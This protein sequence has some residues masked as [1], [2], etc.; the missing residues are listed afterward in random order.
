MG[1]TLARAA[2]PSDWDAAARLLAEHQQWVADALDLDLTAAQPEAGGE[3]T[4]PAS[5][6]RPPDGALV[7]VRSGQQP[8][9]IVGI[10][11]YA[12]TVGEL[13]RMYVQ[14]AA[15]GHGI[16]R[17]LVTAALAAAAELG[18]TELWLQT[19][20][21]TMAAAHRLYRD[22]GF[23][24]IPPY[25]DLGIAGVATLGLRLGSDNPVRSGSVRRRPLLPAV[26]R[27]PRVST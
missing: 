5:F 22:A 15:R 11:R 18:F 23:V 20:P 14:P 17:V 21:A 13:K 26:A 1:I 16:G 27:S 7:L 24:D 25:H 3:F 8:I 10:H 2:T 19:E 9:G 6:Y 12:G 4:D